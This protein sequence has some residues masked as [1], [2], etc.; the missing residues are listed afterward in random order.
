MLF[1]DNPAGAGFSFTSPGGYVKNISQVSDQ[2]HVGL[3]QF[4][5]MFPW[6]QENDF[7]ITGESFAGKYIPGIANTIV[8]RNKV[9]EFKINLK[10][11]FDFFFCC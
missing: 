6:L 11:K 8:E 3:V 4:F 7:F 5:K 1:I 2:L 9:D 10:V